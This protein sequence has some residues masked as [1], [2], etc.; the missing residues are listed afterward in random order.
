LTLP[1]YVYRVPRG[2]AI[3]G[4]VLNP[5]PNAFQIITLFFLELRNSPEIYLPEKSFPTWKPLASFFRFSI[6]YVAQPLRV[7]YTELITFL[8]PFAPFIFVPISLLESNLRFKKEK[9]N[10]GK[11]FKKKKIISN[12]YHL[13]EPKKF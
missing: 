7:Y 13:L 4:K 5:S 9:T 1:L 11:E 6:R 2:H 12:P 10:L 8:F 3:D